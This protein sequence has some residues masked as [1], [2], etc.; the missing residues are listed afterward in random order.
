MAAKVTL[1][2][3]ASAREASGV[4]SLL[5]FEVQSNSSS[6]SAT[7]EDLKTTIIAKY[8]TLEPMLRGS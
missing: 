1:L 6:D 3:F 5:E 2:F 4:S 8:P 7:T